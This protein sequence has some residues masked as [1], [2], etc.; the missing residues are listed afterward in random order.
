MSIKHQGALDI[1]RHS[2]GKIHKQRALSARSQARLSF[3]STKDPIHD[4]ATAVEVRNTVM[5]AHHNSALC[6]SDHLGPMQC[7]NFPDSVIA[8]N[9]HCAR[10][11]TACILNY[12]LAPELRDELVS[13]CAQLS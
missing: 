8:K 13:A 3:I 12:A 4:K 2:E 6:L 1:K 7:K 11:K 10:T 9:Y 5:I